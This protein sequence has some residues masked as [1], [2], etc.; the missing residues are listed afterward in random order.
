MNIIIVTKRGK[1]P[2][3][4]H[5]SRWH[6][7][8][9]PALAFSCLSILL[10]TAGYFAGTRLHPNAELASWQDELM[11]QRQ[12]I[13]EATRNTQ[14][15]IQALTLRLAQL[16]AQTTRLDA[17]GN[18]LVK[19]A[20]L[21]AGEFDFGNL[22]GLGGPEVPFEDLPPAHDFTAELESLAT[23]LVLREEQL[24]A[25]DRLMLSR[26]LQAE[27]TPSGVPVET[28]WISSGYGTRLDPFTGRK[29]FHRGIDIAGREGTDVVAVGGGV[30]IWAGTHHAYGKLIEID[31]GNGYVTR[32]A[33]NKALLVSV[34]EVVKK[35]QNIAR[36]GSTGRATAAH[37]HFEVLKDGRHVN[38]AS[39]IRASN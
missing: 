22:P 35:G 29:A 17:L 31:H 36:M 2:R 25:L 38:P 3:S 27:V 5:L 33:H 7:F 6:H 37:V 1:R 23:A 14:A 18:K 30:V 15:N 26:A 19:M 28:G 4:L 13:D 24:K 16:Q 34:G 20:G 39:Y 12:E 8:V 21:D 10:L 9:V 11:Q 32:Y